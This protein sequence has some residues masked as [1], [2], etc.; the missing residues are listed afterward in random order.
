MK[1]YTG[2]GSPDEYPFASTYEGDAGAQVKGVPL[3]EQRI[4]GG[5]LA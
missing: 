1:G 4:Q 2:L 5:K 3:Q